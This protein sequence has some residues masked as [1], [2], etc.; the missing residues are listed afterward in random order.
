[1][2]QLKQPLNKTLYSWLH[3]AIVI[4]GILVI[5]IITSLVIVCRT[6][7]VNGELP[8]FINNSAGFLLMAFLCLIITVFMYRPLQKI[9]PMYIFIAGAIIWTIIGVIFFLQAPN[10]VDPNSQDQRAVFQIAET[11]HNGSYATFT[12]ENGPWSW[13]IVQYPF[14]LGLV[15]LERIAMV[16]STNIYFF[17][18]LNLIMIILIIFLQWRLVKRFAKSNRVMENYTLF[19]SF[20]YLPLLFFVIWA[21][22]NIPSMVFILLALYF[23]LR[24]F[25]DSQK[26]RFSWIGV[27]L[28]SATA[29][30]IRSNSLIPVIAIAI[31]FTLKAIEWKKVTPVLIAIATILS[32]SLSMKGLYA[33][34]EHESGTKLSEG[35]P[36]VAWITMGLQDNGVTQGWYNF[37]GPDVFESNGQDTEKTKEAATKDLKKQVTD[38]VEHPQKAVVFFGKKLASTWSDPMCQSIFSPPNKPFYTDI[39]DH[40]NEPGTHKK[41]MYR[42]VVAMNI[43]TIIITLT[44]LLYLIFNWKHTNN[45]YS[46]LIM[47][48]V[49]GFIFHLL[50]ETKPQYVFQYFFSLIPITAAGLCAAGQRLWHKID[51]LKK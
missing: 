33:Y 38:F 16:F 12:Q 20:A 2:A 34:Y 51:T 18:T 32:L 21:Y 49:G 27:I 50:W 46:F 15:T 25:E 29:Y 19:L 31:L 35:I 36:K 43:V 3:R 41:L 14:Q 10:V 6:W 30:L 26:Y 1:M 24:Y 23:T 44:S 17:Y 4:C 37:Y 13:Y 7:M 42:I 5:G 9:K 48:V 40:L 39:S 45:Y 47:F 22:G 11:I 28:C 8:V